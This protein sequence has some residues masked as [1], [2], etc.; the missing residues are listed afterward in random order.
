MNIRINPIVFNL[1]AIAALLFCL[2]QVLVIAPPKTVPS[3]DEAVRILLKLAEE[4]DEVDADIG[5]RVAA[6]Q[7]RRRGF[8]NGMAVTMTVAILANVI[9][10]NLGRARQRANAAR[11]RQLEAELRGTRSRR[12]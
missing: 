6:D 7:A 1:I 12:S 5:F 10:N 3:T 9:A 8:S 2:V 11:I 4:D